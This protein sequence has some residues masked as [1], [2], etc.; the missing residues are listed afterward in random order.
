[1]LTCNVLSSSRVFSRMLAI[2]NTSACLSAHC[3]SLHSSTTCLSPA[4][5]PLDA[6]SA[7]LLKLKS[8]G[9][10][11]GP[12][13]SYLAKSLQ[14]ASFTDAWAFMSASALHSARNN[15]HPN[16]LQAYNRIHIQLWTHSQ[17]GDD[18]ISDLD[19]KMAKFLD[20]RSANATQLDHSSFLA[21]ANTSL[22][23]LMQLKPTS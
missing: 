18:K 21:S 19:I 16:V 9:W 3:K 14:F 15:H 12:Q 6:K 5:T 22:E 10:T 20:K 17:V 11:V 7:A 13:N 1:M 8:T 4:E 2:T 23:A